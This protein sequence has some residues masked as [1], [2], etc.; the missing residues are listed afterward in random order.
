MTKLTRNFMRIGL[1][2]SLCFSVLFG[3]CKCS[4]V[5]GFEP[6]G[7]FYVREVNIDEE[8][9]EYSGSSYYK[10]YKKE[11]LYDFSHFT[12]DSEE[13]TVVVCKSYDDTQVIGGMFEYTAGKSVTSF[14]D[15]SYREYTPSKLTVTLENGDV[16]EGE[17]EHGGMWKSERYITL[18]GAG[19]SFR[20]ESGEDW[21]GYFAELYETT[22]RKMGELLFGTVIV[23]DMNAYEDNRY[24]QAFRDFYQGFV[25]RERLFIYPDGEYNANYYNVILYVKD[26]RGLPSFRF[27][28]VVEGKSYYI[29]LT[30]L[31]KDWE[32]LDEDWVDKYK[33]GRQVWNEAHT[34]VS[35]VTE[36]QDPNFAY[37]ENLLVEIVHNSGDESIAEAFVRDLKFSTIAGENT[38]EDCLTADEIIALD[39]QYENLKET[40]GQYNGEKIDGYEI[41]DDIIYFEQTQVGNETV[42]IYRLLADN[43]VIAEESVFGLGRFYHQGKFYTFNGYREISLLYLHF[44]TSENE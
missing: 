17:T 40:D 15:E 4:V 16:F 41:L 27:R 9:N 5:V 30:Y 18:S 2:F 28:F 31:P 37:S 39:K 43:R 44:Y 29:N 34:T 3:A 7:T 14:M 25:D 12:F 22:P 36:Y 23:N 1:L 32:E 24:P 21:E 26:A 19:I 42:R 8:G 35:F 6:N 33:D 10:T 38:V 20:L 11:H 13:K